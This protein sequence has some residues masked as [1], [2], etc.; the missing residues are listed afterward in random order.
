MRLFHTLLLAA[1]S[2]LSQGFARGDTAADFRAL[3]AAEWEYTMEQSPT[4]ASSLGDRRWNDRWPDLSLPARERQAQ[5][6]R[7]LLQRLRALDR[8]ALPHGERLNYDLFLYET[9]LAIEEHERR[10]WTLAINQRDG[11]QLAD[12]LAD[13]LRFETVKDYEDW[14]ARLRALPALVE[15]NIAILRLGITEKRTHAKVVLRAVPEQIAKQLPDRPEASPFYKPFTKFAAD[16]SQPERE[17]LVAAA[18]D[19]I[20][21]RVIP[22]YRSFRDFFEKEYLPACTDA[23]GAWQWPD[24]E[25]AYAFTARA[26]TTTDLPPHEIH[27]IGLRE[28]ERITGE[29]QKIMDQVG[30]KGTR[31]EFFEHLRTDPKFFYKTGDELLA[32]YRAVAKR[33]DPLLVKL[34]KTLP[35]TPYGVEPIPENSAPTN[36]AAYYRQPAA[37]GSRAGTFFANLYRPEMRPKHEMMALT[38]HE[39]VPGHHLQIALAYEQGELPNFRRYGGGYTAYVE[40]WALY[41]ESLGDELGL[42]DDPY[43]KFGQLTYEIWRAC[44]LVIDTGIHAQRWTRR[45]AIDYLLAHSPKTRLDVEN[46]IDRYISWPGQALAYKIGELRIKDLRAKSKATLGEKFDVREFHDELLRT[47]PV[48]LEVLERGVEEWARSKG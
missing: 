24:G 6:H 33:V 45:Q 18:R 25:A 12:E 4:W 39:A 46:E 47:G 44:R 41:A 19:A 48:P 31:Q 17:R 8:A 37:D 13:A 10:L 3:L 42:Y 11:I 16:I 22:A 43:S 7:D 23:V 29:M 38:L 1:A 35:R 21:E 2:L 5:H 26:F 40:G 28:V 34:F 36:T 15:Q 14:I 30:W 9:Q 27:Q 20:A 32:G